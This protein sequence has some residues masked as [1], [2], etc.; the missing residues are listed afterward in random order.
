MNR[1]FQSDVRE[2]RK[3]VFTN[4]QKWFREAV[5]CFSMVHNTK[6]LFDGNIVQNDSV[7]HCSKCCQQNCK[8]QCTECSK[9]Q[10]IASNIGP[11]ERFAFLD[12]IRL[13]LVINVCIDHMF[14]FTPFLSFMAFRRILN[15][16]ITKVS[17]SIFEFICKACI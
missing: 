7:K 8:M 16:V 14:L 5:K 10:N 11:V 6:A 2:K 12:A 9:N 1:V 13:I 17:Q 15:S 3:K 4:S